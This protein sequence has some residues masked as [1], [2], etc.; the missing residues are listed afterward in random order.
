MA[1]SFF[2]A[3]KLLTQTTHLFAYILLYSATTTAHQSPCFYLAHI[4]SKALG[5][6][7]ARREVVGWGC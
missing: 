3:P 4:P 5:E 1:L 6:M 2:N 7:G